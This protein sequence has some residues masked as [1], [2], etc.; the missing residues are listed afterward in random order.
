MKFYVPDMSCGHCTAAIEKALKAIDPNATVDTDLTS[1][2]VTVA[3]AK[4]A[5]ALQVALKEADYPATPA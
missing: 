2:T 5:T 4:D 1:K 3:S